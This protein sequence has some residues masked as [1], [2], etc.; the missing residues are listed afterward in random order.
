MK[1]I[2]RKRTKAE[3]RKL[4]KRLAL[5]TLCDLIGSIAYAMGIYTFAKMANFSPGGISGIALIMNYL[6]NLPIGVMTLIMNIPLV[7]V[8]YKIVGPRFLAKT[9]KSMII[10]TIFL[11]VIFPLIPLYEGNRMMAALYSGLLMGAGM[12][13]LYMRGSSSG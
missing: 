7:I 13:F 8:S 5:D 4:T 3:I 6:W 10:S 2:F 11:D 9:A 12:A 1:K